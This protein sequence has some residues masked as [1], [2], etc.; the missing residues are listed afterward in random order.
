[1]KLMDKLSMQEERLWY[2]HKTIENGWSSNVLD[3]R[4]KSRLIER[5][6]K[7]VNNF[8]A[9]LMP[10]DSDM[11]NQIFKDPCL[12]DFLE[13]DMPKREVEIER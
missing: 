4:I 12:F 10:A 1:M 5:T 6:G 8:P 3:F 11:A 2:A 7:S 9:A 13:T